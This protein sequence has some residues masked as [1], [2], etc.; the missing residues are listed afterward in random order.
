[1]TNYPIFIAGSVA[2]K[3]C[4]RMNR[5]GRSFVIITIC[6]NRF[7]LVEGHWHKVTDRQTVLAWDEHAQLCKKYLE[8]GGVIAV[9]GYIELNDAG[10][11][12]IVAENL[13]F[14]GLRTTIHGEQEHENQADH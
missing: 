8:V 10:K 7:S 3:P 9:D 4:L 2:R 11:P 1:M 14:L 12:V 13:H 5:R 6:T